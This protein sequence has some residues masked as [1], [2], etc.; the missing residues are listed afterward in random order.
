[1]SLDNGNGNGERALTRARP[2]TSTVLAW[3]L[4]LLLIVVV[5]LLFFVRLPAGNESTFN[6][7]L[8]ALLGSL[9]TIV[10]FYFGDSKKSQ[11]QAETISTL[12][13]KQP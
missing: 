1:M 7:V 3:G 5:V 2:T 11:Q 10:S 6:L 12:A 13:N 9:T 4:M 8:G